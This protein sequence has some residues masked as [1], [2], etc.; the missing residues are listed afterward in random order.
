MSPGPP[1][2]RGLLG[3]GLDR[4]LGVLHVAAVWEAPDGRYLTLRVG[5]GAPTSASDAVVLSAAR[6]RAD[7]I[8]TTGRILRDEPKLVHASIAP[9]EI[10][11]ELETLRRTVWGLSGP[12]WIAV[13][14]RSGDVP[15]RHPAIGQAERLLFF[16]GEAG[17]ARL[18]A[19][20]TLPERAQIVESTSPSAL[21]LLEHLERACGACSIVIEAGATTAA[22][23]YEGDGRVDELWL[24]VCQADF[25]APGDLVGPF[26]ARDTIEAALGAPRHA[27]RHLEGDVVWT[28]LV[29]QRPVAPRR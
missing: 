10:T 19:N 2:L 15:G 21:A 18:R 14:T 27:E 6:A 13:L 12:P 11:A 25:I 16:T 17:A 7:A 1:D 22:P 5:E 26:V 28:T 8:V 9:P 20:A 24:S 29:H 3:P 4:A 23:L